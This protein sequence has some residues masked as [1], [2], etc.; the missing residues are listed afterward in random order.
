MFGANPMPYT[1]TSNA[2]RLHFRD[3]VMKGTPPPPSKY[4][5][6][7][8]GFLVDPTKEAIGF[9]SIPGVPSTAPT[10]LINRVLDYDWGAG[11]QLP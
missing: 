4:P 9:P 8:N 11:L 2:I 6:L 5:T 10:G 1:E 7:A 3:W